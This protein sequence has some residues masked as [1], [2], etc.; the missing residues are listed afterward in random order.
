MT[1]NITEEVVNSKKNLSIIIVC[2]AYDNIVKEKYY[3]RNWRRRCLRR[4]IAGGL[5]P[6]F[7]IEVF[8]C[9]SNVIWS[10]KIYFSQKNP[11]KCNPKLKMKTSPWSPQ[12]NLLTT[13]INKRR[14]LSR[15]EVEYDGWFLVFHIVLQTRT[16]IFMHRFN[17]SFV[18][19]FYILR[20]TPGIW[21]SPSTERLKIWEPF[22]MKLIWGLQSWPL[23]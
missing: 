23:A 2:Y 9:P 13:R 18:F 11:P 1:P 22:K 3:I 14:A 19:H 12:Y 8:K 20:L 17:M 7:K 16:I 5:W 21:T 6:V 15:Q 10:F 4:S